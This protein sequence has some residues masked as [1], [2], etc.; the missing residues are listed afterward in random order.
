MKKINLILSMVLI[1]LTSMTVSGQSVKDLSDAML[2]ASL[3]SVFE[4]EL[5]NRNYNGVYKLAYRNIY[6]TKN[7]SPI[8]YF[9]MGA[10]LE[11]GMGTSE[12]SQY[13]AKAHYEKGAQLGSRE[14]Q[15]RLNEINSS[16][17]WGANDAN[18]EAFARLYGKPGAGGAAPSP[19][20][21]PSPRTKYKC[22]SCNGT[23][24]CEFCGGSGWHYNKYDGKRHICNSCSHTGRCQK[25]NGKGT[26]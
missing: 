13:K 20:S 5:F 6:E 12:V 10:C 9:Y 21:S 26:L 4:S 22:S 3:K 25:C 7:C 1:M 2:N 24:L 15:Q 16:G 8:S 18:R 14:C 19:G 11:L 23:G 17:Y